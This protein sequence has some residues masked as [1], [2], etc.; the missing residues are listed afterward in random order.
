MGHISFKEFE[1]IPALA[2]RF[3]VL[4]YYKVIDFPIVSHLFNVKICF[5]HLSSLHVCSWKIFCHVPL[6]GS[7]VKK[8][9]YGTHSY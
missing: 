6:E 9:V 1:L 4:F 5:D 2:F 7:L 8:L 3:S